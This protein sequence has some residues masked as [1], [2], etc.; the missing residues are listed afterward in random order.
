MSEAVFLDH[1]ALQTKGSSLAMSIQAGQALC[2][3]GPAASGKSRLLAVIGKLEKPVRGTVHVPSRIS[4]AGRP[5]LSRRSKPLS[6]ARKAARDSAT[7]SEVLTTLRLWD[8]RNRPISQL[9][10]AQVVACELVEPL[11]KSDPLLIIDGHLD[12]LDPWSLE[13]ALRLLR[14]RLSRGAAAVVATNR[15]DLV[16][17][18]D[19]VVVLKDQAA[20]FAGS[21]D[22]L[23]LRGPERRIEIETSEPSGVRALVEPFEVTVRETEGGVSMQAREG[24]AVAAHLLLEG[25]GSTKFVYLRRQTVEEALNALIG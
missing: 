9:S 12:F 4:V 17:R 24:Q 25:Y 13:G 23:R 7:A 22:E 1:V 21:P 3:V 8:V 2:V 5:G 20:V 11:S 16:E 15:A 6:I 18:F 19:A 14:M 10:E